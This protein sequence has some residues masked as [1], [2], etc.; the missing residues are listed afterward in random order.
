MSHQLP[1]LPYPYDALEPYIDELTMHIHHDKHHAAYVNNLNAALEPYADLKDRPVQALLRN[2]DVLPEAIRTAAR[3]NGGAHAAHSL[4]WEILTPG[5]AQEPTGAL[6]RAIAETFG[7][8]AALKDLLTKTAITRFGSGWAWLVVTKDGK[9]GVYSTAN[10]DSP[11]SLG[12]T[13]ILTI[14]V[15]EHAY[16]LLYQNRRPDHVGAICNII[17]WDVVG[18]KYAAAAP[19]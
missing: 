18:Q 14:D 9:L 7:S 8:F 19:R 17:N 2:L 1:A 3:N 12:D 15:W 13:P 5:G 4:Y 10:Q 16:Y 11:I 6:A